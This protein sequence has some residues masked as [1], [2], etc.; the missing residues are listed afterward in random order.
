VTDRDRCFLIIFFNGF[1]KTFDESPDLIQTALLD[2]TTASRIAQERFVAEKK[3]GFDRLG[4][5]SMWIRNRENYMDD[6]V[7]EFQKLNR[8]RKR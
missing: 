2:F 6:L 8:A 1:T 5:Q 3:S 7:A 4:I